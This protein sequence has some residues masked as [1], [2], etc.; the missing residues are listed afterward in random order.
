MGGS[1]DRESATSVDKDVGSTNYT[2]TGTANM[3]T[4]GGQ[5][6]VT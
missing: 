1:R 2:E 3:Q 4:M 6:H 5:I